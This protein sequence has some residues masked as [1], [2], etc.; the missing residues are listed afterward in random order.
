MNWRRRIVDPIGQV[1]TPFAGFR[2]DGFYTTLRGGGYNNDF[3]NRFGVQ[4]GSVGRFMPAIGLNYEYPLLVGGGA[5][6]THVI[7]PVAQ[8]IARPN[9]SKIGRTPNEDSQSVYFDDTN[10]FQWSR[11]SGYDRNEG[12][13]RTTY[14]LNY[15]GT[16]GKSAYANAMIGQSVQLSGRNSYLAYDSAGAGINSGLETRR[17][18]F[19]A[20]AQFAP[21][22]YG[23]FTVKGRFDE[24]DFSPRAIEASAMA[25]LGPVTGS[26]TYARYDAQPER[27]QAFRREGI[28]FSGALKFAQNW[29]VRSTVLYDLDKYLT[30]RVF[31]P[32]RSSPRWSIS[33]LYLGLNYKDECTTFD[34]LYSTGFQD[35][36]T[37][38]RQRTSQSLMFRLELRTLGGVTFRQNVDDLST[39]GRSDGILR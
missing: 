10:L 26:V 7:S 39:I 1:W 14:G 17:S 18:D 8:I 5:A 22:P 16:F 20:R 30:D 24:R 29:S 37:G 27:G 23:V 38:T 28:Q 25:Y 3:Q 32:G 12:G 35:S 2:A 6:G 21:N 34:V 19:V 33:A 15:S 4:E 9:E 31:T 13:V 11:F 36:S